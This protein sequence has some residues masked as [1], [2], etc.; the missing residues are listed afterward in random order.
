[1]RLRHLIAAAAAAGTMA[2]TVTPSHA[3]VNGSAA[4]EGAYPFM[5]AITDTS[6]FQFC[7]G[8]VIA[9]NW[10]LTAAHCLVDEQAKNVRVVTGR[11]DLGNTST[12]Q[13]HNVTAI[14]IHPKYDGNAWDAALLQL[15][16]STTSPAIQLAAAANDNL[17]TP[18]TVVRVAGWG[19]Q[20]NTLGLTATNQLRYVDLKV[21][22]D[23]QCGQTNFGFHGATGVCAEELAKDSCQGD[24]GGPLFWNG[25]PRI[26]IGIV[27]Y[28]TGCGLPKF[29]GVYSEVNNPD[30]RSFITQYAGV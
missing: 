13:V 26:Q 9:P 22:G 18:G 24:S 21:V 3:I 25:S 23:S 29:P 14:R 20:T 6:G 11:T 16:S 2:V 30:I 5:A 7:G 10:V 4:P 27:S 19:D 1:M 8:S 17:E 15:S 28:G 12:G